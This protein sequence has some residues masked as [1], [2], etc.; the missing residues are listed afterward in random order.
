MRVLGIDPGFGRMGWAIVE[1]SRSRQELVECGCLET[2][3]QDSLNVRLE[4]IYD[5]MVDLIERFRPEAVAVEDLFFF[6]NQK[7]VMAVGQ[8]R[9]VI[10]LAI[11]K[12]KV[13]CFNYTPL[14]IKNTVAGYGRA[15][16]QQMQLMVKSQLRLKS[17]PKPDDAAD[18]CAAALT[19]FFMGGLDGL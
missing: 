2:S 5:Q 3:P 9:G 6:K 10:L 19:H 17:V 7:T 13:E 8:A 18:A 14:Q 16:K 4:E 12:K 15:T 1:G 11:V